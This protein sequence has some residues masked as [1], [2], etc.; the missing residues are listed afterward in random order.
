MYS[1]EIKN[2]RITNKKT[3]MKTAKGTGIPQNTIYCVLLH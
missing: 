1:K 2:A 3:Q